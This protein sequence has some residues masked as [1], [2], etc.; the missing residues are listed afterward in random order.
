MDVRAVNLASHSKWLNGTLRNFTKPVFTL[1]KVPAIRRQVSLLNNYRVPPPAP[2]CSVIAQSG[3]NVDN[4][5]PL[6]VG[7][8]ICF[9]ERD[10]IVLR[11]GL[12]PAC[13]VHCA[14]S[15][16]VSARLNGA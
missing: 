15:H 1:C 4:A 11:S 2:K 13:F 8:P 3:L 5:R 7:L 14:R 10:L 6:L 9:L 12:D 16:C